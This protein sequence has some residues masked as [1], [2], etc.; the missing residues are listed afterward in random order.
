[1]HGGKA[2]KDAY[3]PFVFLIPR[4]QIQETRRHGNTLS[5]IDRTANVAS[6]IV[7]KRFH[8]LFLQKSDVLKKGRLG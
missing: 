8:G 7:R 5:R 4:P 6:R 2:G 1:V 3:S